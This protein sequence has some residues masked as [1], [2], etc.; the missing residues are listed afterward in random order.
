MHGCWLHKHSNTK[1]FQTK[2]I[3]IYLKLF[4]QMQV[5]F[6]NTYLE[7][8]ATS[9]V[10]IIIINFLIPGKVHIIVNKSDP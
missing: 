6:E 2:K 10:R 5:C 9:T 3:L 4:Y 7:E 1:F 8:L